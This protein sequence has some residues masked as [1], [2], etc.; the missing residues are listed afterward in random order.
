VNNKPGPKSAASMSVVT[1]TFPRVRVPAHL[2]ESQRSRIDGLLG[3]KPAD[4]F[5]AADMPL[6]IELARHMDRADRVD[7]EIRALK[8]DDLQGLKWLQQLANAESSRIQ[9][10]MRSLRL[11]PQA[12]YRADAVKVRDT[13]GPRPW[14]T[15]PTSR[16]NEG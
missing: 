12:R 8:A 15:E 6:L 14:E 7:A 3:T 1:T 4:W 13:D 2:P 11:T 5:Q 9:S 16:G 10:V